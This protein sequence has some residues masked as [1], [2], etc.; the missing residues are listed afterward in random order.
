MSRE[1]EL[2]AME[3]DFP[4]PSMRRQVLMALAERHA[5]GPFTVPS[6]EL[7]ARLNLDALQLWLAIM[8]LRRNS[9]LDCSGLGGLMTVT[10]G[11]DFAQTA[12]SSAL[13]TGK[14]GHL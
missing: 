4:D 12:K 10:L 7:C 9:L 5:G 13:P 11:L 14:E 1:A 3:Q 2:W 6:G 8:D